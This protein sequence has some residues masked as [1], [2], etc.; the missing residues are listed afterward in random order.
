MAI[1][2]PSI[3]SNVTELVRGQL[4]AA[5]FATDDA[6][7]VTVDTPSGLMKTREANTS[8]GY[9][10]LFFY[11]F[12]PSGLF[13]DD[14]LHNRWQ[15]RS[16]CMITAFSV[17]GTESVGEG[18]N[19]EE[20]QVSESEIDLR[21]LGEVLRYF[22]E[23]PE[24]SDDN[25]GVYLRAILSPLSSDEINQ[26]WSTQGDA[27]YRPSLLYEFT[28]IPVEPR[29]FNRPD[30]PVVAGGMSLDSHADMD[31]QNE[32]VPSAGIVFSPRLEVNLDDNWVP[33]VAL[34]SAAN[35]IVQ[36]LSFAAGGAPAS[37]SIWIAGPA[38][39]NIDIIWQQ[40]V[41]GVWSDQDAPADA[42]PIPAQPGSIPQLQIDPQADVATVA[43][44]SIN[45]P[46]GTEPLQY[47]LFVERNDNG[48]LRRS[49]PLIITI[50]DIW[51]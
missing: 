19:A 11:R 38:G 3:L 46:S 47:L 14:S 21:V 24:L 31:A 22:Y 26:I 18:G 2:A 28:L 7:D 1:P 34:I 44:L 50:G 42:R 35:E 8:R 4:A 51:S 23:S 13:G 36:T 20:V 37:V 48:T 33:Q 15:V 6:Y 16:F 40:S 43:T 9:L 29:R 45:V 10:N 25:L 39:E 41:K 32:P 17:A 27:A 49:N 30:A 12:E 5:L